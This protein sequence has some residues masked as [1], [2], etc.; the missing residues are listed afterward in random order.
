MLITFIHLECNNCSNPFGKHCSFDSAKQLRE[1]AY[2][3][4][5]AYV[6]GEDYCP[7]CVIKLGIKV[8]GRYRNSK[9]KHTTH[10][11]QH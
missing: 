1:T 3:S 2:K 5:W 8:R 7:E 4:G 9:I 6:V 11:K 10:D